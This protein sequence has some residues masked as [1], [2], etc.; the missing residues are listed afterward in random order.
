MYAGT[1]YTGNEPKLRCNGFLLIRFLTMNKVISDNFEFL[2]F[3][4]FFITK[5]YHVFKFEKKWISK[6]K[7]FPKFIHGIK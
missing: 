2:F 3:K 5:G 4:Q 7:I 1:G 6:S